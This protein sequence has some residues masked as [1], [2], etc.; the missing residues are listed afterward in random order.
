MTVFRAGEV[1]SKQII[2]KA[3]EM[4]KFGSVVFGHKEDRFVQ[5]NARFEE[6]LKAYEERGTQI[7]SLENQVFQ[8]EKVLR[9]ER[10]ESPV[11]LEL[12]TPHGHPLN[13]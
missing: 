7:Q 1:G 4:L 11:H 6:V 10:W 8:M 5:L 2:G 3:S 13:L 12:H 9:K